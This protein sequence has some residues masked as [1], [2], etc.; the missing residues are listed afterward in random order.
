MG[1]QLAILITI[2]FCLGWTVPVSA[3][4]PPISPVMS[5]RGDATA[6]LLA[7]KRC[8]VMLANHCPR[9]CNDC[10]ARRANCHAGCGNT[11]TC[12]NRCNA[13]YDCVRECS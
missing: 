4:G 13:N 9:C 2:T 10:Q 3:G 1:R 5:C 8:D 12:I 7:R 11:G 6:T